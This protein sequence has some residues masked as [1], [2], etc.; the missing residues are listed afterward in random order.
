MCI[1]IYIYMADSP[2]QPQLK[3]QKCKDFECELKNTYPINRT[4]IGVT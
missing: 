4:N 3:T 2:D 1:Y